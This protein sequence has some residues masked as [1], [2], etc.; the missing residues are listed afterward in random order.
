MS[1]RFKFPGPWWVQAAAASLFSWTVQASSYLEQS[2]YFNYNVAS[3]AVPVPVTTQ[4]DTIHIEW[5]RGVATGPN[6][7][8]PYSLQIYTSAF[9]FP[10]IVAAG[11]GLSFDWQVPFGPGTLYQICMF[12]KNGNSGGCEAVY[13]M[14]ANTTATPSCANATFP[15]GPLDVE[16]VVSDGPMSQYGWVNS[17]TDIQVTPKNGTA[18][19]TFTIAPALHPPYNITSPDEGSMNWTVSLSWASPFF[20]SVVDAD[21]NFWSQGP[22][23]SGNGDTACLSDNLERPSIGKRVTAATAIGSGIGGLV[24]GLA[25]GVGAAFFFRSPRQH[26]QQIDEPLLL[27]SQSSRYHAVPSRPLSGHLMGSLGS[28]SS[29]IEMLNRSGRNSDHYF[30]E[31]FILPEEDSSQRRQPSSSPSAQ[32]DSHRRRLSS[33][34]STQRRQL[35]SP[36]SMQGSHPL[37]QTL[38]PVQSPHGSGHVYVVHHDGGRAPVTIYHE[39]GTE[40]VELPP[41]YIVGDPMD[42]NHPSSQDTQNDAIGGGGTGPLTTSTL[43]LDP[44]RIPQRTRKTPRPPDH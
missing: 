34:P 36:T 19:Y 33:P 18:P 27:S 3:Q 20:I 10:F 38:S 39:D 41:R 35:S 13:T 30:I 29:N 21:G 2:F 14:I 1:R 6:P 11:S 4:C 12:D 5:E 26:Q 31:P 25:I 37:E 43:L 17:C 23:H 40:V 15:L 32:D 7:T 22:L 42:D 9:V 44:P 8:A 16:A 28:T 24:A